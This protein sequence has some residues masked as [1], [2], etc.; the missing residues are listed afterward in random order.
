[1]T[2]TKGEVKVLTHVKGGKTLKELSNE[3]GLSKGYLS[4]ILHSL[5]R[6]GLVV[7]EGKKPLIIKPA[8]N[9]VMI[10]FRLV[11]KSF[12][13][14]PLDELLSGGNLKVLSALKV[15]TP[16]PLW[17]LLLRANVSRATLYRALK[18][19]RE[20]LIV[21][22]REEG[23]FLV[24]RFAPLKTFADEYFYLQNSM[25]AMEFDPNATLVWSGVEEMILAT[26]TFKGKSVDGFQL[27]GLARFSDYGIPLISSGIY[28]YYWP[29][30][31]LSLEDVVVHT[32]VS[33]YGARE[34]LYVIVLLKTHPFDKKKL[35]MLATKFEVI[36][37]LNDILEYLT[38]KKKAYPFP[39]EEEVKELCNQYFGGCEE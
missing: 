23:Y 37:T 14:L 29:A 20:R 35:Q 38:G 4:T 3:L 33:L 1:M 32:L 30:E 28:H 11:Q 8:E 6:K 10:I 12:S 36:N 18:E 27:T 9:K 39:S 22:K 16:Q 13:Y 15:E 31:E 25:K 5:E 21:G 24:E 2:L 17:L 7:F 19:L 34:L 26:T